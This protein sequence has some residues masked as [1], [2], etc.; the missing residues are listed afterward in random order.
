MELKEPMK[1]NEELI[2]ASQEVSHLVQE[3]SQEDSRFLRE[4]FQ[5]FMESFAQG[6]SHLPSYRLHPLS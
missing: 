5:K 6:Y 3:Q 2:R 1:T 4:Q